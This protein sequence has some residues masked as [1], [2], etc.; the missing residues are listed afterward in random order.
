[1]PVAT[2]FF[3]PIDSD[4]ALQDWHDVHNAIIPADPLTLDDVRDRVSR[5]HLE[6]A[7]AHGVLVGCSTVRPPDAD[8][9]ATVIVRVLPAHR[10][11]GYGRSSYAR[12]LSVARSL[13]ASGIETVVWEPNVDGL[14][15]ALANGF[16]E[17]ERYVLDGAELAYIHLRLR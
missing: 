6:V 9:I 2:L 3:S 13:G 8:G 1:V 15:F 4:Q 16:A 12:A 7:Y 14:K 5:N 10:H 11:L 17:T